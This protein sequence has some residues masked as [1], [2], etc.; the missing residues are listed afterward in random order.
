MEGTVFHLAVESIQHI[1]DTAADIVPVERRTDHD[2]VGAFHGIDYFV[3]SVT[4]EILAVSADGVVGEVQDFIVSA[5]EQ[6]CRKCGGIAVCNVTID[7]R[8]K[9]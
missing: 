5:F 6:L 3:Q 2:G 4:G 9:E 8:Q 7:V 1:A